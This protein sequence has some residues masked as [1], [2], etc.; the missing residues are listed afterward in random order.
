MLTLAQPYTILEENMNTRIDNPS[1]ADA[2]FSHPYGKK[3]HQWRDD[4]S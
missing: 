2:S 4:A 1:S 3:P